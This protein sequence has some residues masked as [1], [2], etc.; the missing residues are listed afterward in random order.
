MTVLRDDL[1]GGR[2]DLSEVLDGGV[3]PPIHP[4]E[5]LR[6]DFLEPLGLSVYQLANA[7]K[8][9]RSRLNDV[10]LGRRA[11]SADTALRLARYFGMTPQFWVNL[12]A[13]YDLDVASRAVGAQIERDV[14]PRAA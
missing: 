7:L 9:S 10:A 4:G 8:T 2:V 13:R 5:V 12:Q 1:D 11:V 3:L 14:A 6:D